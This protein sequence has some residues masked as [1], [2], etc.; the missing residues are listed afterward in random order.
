[1]ALLN[2]LRLRM[3]VLF[4]GVSCVFLAGSSTVFYFLMLR[5]LSNESHE[6]RLEIARP[7]LDEITTSGSIAVIERLNLPGEYFELL[8]SKGQ[9][10]H[11]SLNLNGQPLQLS[12][13]PIDPVAPTFERVYDDRFGVLIAT[14]VP[15]QMGDGHF[16]LAAAT[17]SRISL[18]LKDLRQLF[19]LLLPVGLLFTGVAAAWY[20]SRSLRPIRDLTR[21]AAET[22]KLITDPQ[23]RSTI[24]A[25]PVGN[26]ADELGQLALTFNQLFARIDRMVEQMRQFV[27]DASHELRTPL[28]ILQGET[29]LVL[30]GERTAA[31]YKQTLRILESE[32]KKL[33]RIVE[34]LFTLS[35]AD[36]GE[37]RLA[38][39]FLDLS[40]LVAA[41]CQLVLPRAVAKDIRIL[42][43][44][45]SEPVQYLGDESFLSQLFIDLLDNAIKY[46]ASSTSIRAKLI[47]AA[48]GI[49]IIF[50]DEGVG[51]SEQ[52]QRHIFERFYRAQTSAGE[53]HGGGLGLSI[54]SA[55]VAAHGGS[56]GLNSK[57]GE[58]STFTIWLPPTDEI[59]GS[60]R[61]AE[62]PC[63]VDY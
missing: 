12:A 53:G 18:I 11:E 27:S 21:H 38:R 13:K 14:L 3:I 37:L 6:Q 20:V 9:V 43:D 5:E 52:D 41:S 58:G 26:S 28:S 50:Q 45:P 42:S 34:G 2:S 62:F 39:E 23:R 49:H 48:D 40:E 17:Q 33:T 61:D 8:D 51:I 15:F 30:S 63:V 32:L 46:S 55:I 36:A 4:C 57:L 47:T 31:E 19:M 10:L 60:S 16:V 54:A 44:V 59:A 56:I 29:E 1:M 24:I 35:M 25:L 22:T 7:V